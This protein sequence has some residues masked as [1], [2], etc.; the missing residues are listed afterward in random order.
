M[1]MSKKL[2]DAEFD[3]MMELLSKVS[4]DHTQDYEINTFCHLVDRYIMSKAIVEP[5]IVCLCGST[6]FQ[7]FFEQAN[8]RETLAG[9]IVLGTGGIYGHMEGM[10]MDGP[11]KQMLD[12]LHKAKIRLA[13]EILVLDACRPYCE[14]CGYWLAM[15]VVIVP[16]Y[17]WPCPKCHMPVVN[18]PYFGESTKSEIAYAESLGK[19][20]RYYSKER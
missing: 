17:K 3:Q 13:H 7:E 5:I 9:K 19:R 11:V 16:G 12:A 8:R 4:S 10:D 15:T 18:K 6:R 1:A 14:K 20:I 2:N